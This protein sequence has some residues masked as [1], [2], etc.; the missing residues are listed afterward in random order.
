[1]ARRIATH[2][3]ALDAS[4]FVGLQLSATLSIAWITDDDAVTQWVGRS[5]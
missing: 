5:N 4:D 3:C 1:M 2:G